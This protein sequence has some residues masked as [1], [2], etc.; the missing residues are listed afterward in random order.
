MSTQGLTVGALSANEVYEKVVQGGLTA[1][2]ANSFV[3]EWLLVNAGRARRVFN[4]QQPF[5]AVDTD[6]RPAFARTFEHADW[7]DGESVVQASQTAEEQGFNERFHRIENDL[8]ALYRDVAMA[9]TCLNEMR[10]DLRNLL[11]ELRAEINRVNADIDECCGRHGSVPLAPYHPGYVAAG[12]FLG[13]FKVNEKLMQLWQTPSGM[14]FLPDLQTVEGPIWNDPRAQRSAQF[15]RLLEE[16]ANV[17]E[18]FPKEVGV[19][20]FSKRFGKE[21]LPNGKLVKDLLVILPD[22][23][24][25]AS[26]DAMAADIGDREA[27]ALRTT[28]GARDAAALSLG[29]GGQAGGKLD[30]APIEQFTA[31][32]LAARTALLRNDIA[33]VGKL[34]GMSVNQFAEIMGREKVGNLTRGDMAEAVS[35][36]KLVGKL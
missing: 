9:F 30:T 36:A 20:E 18:A 4:Y 31:L 14:V 12:S 33:T 29:L 21:Q 27:V 2:Q 11:D 26:L 19:A 6:C 34:A 3:G 22:D 35:V 24:K 7:I 5:A 17:R 28:S 16:N 32:P 23:A 8:D 25:F 1:S 10:H 15:V 13:K